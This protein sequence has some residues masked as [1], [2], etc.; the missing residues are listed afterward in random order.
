MNQHK[1]LDLFSD[2]ELAKFFFDGNMDAFDVLHA[3]YHKYVT[4]CCYKV[5]WDKDVAEEVAQESFARAARK[6]RYFLENSE[7]GNFKAWVGK[8]AYHLAINRWHNEKRRK[9]AMTNLT[10]SQLDDSHASKEPGPVRLLEAKERQ[11]ALRK[12]ADELPE[13]TRTYF[14]DFYFREMKRE[15]IARI[16]EISMNQVDYHLGCG[17]AIVERKMW[18]FMRDY[19]N[20]N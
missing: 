16:Y 18:K 14:A 19:K 3:R 2:K 13:P 15:E 9:L 6:I 20:R 1:D 5:F 17:R 7:R 8:I 10:S 4:N 11:E 12:A